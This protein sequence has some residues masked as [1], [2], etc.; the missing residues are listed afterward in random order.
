MEIY[1]PHAGKQ[2]AL[3][4]RIWAG[5]VKQLPIGE[6][7]K[8]RL[9]AMKAETI[10]QNLELIPV[11]V[12]ISAREKAGRGWTIGRRRFAETNEAVL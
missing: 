11:P 4:S 1:Y 2:K 7:D 8:F 5:F 12:E 10:V 3:N 6:R 9:K